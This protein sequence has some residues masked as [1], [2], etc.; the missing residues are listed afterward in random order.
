MALGQLH[1]F[2]QHDAQGNLFDVELVGYLQRL[3]D[4][5]AVLHESHVKGHEFMFEVTFCINL[6]S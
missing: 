1:S 3:S 4:I 2:A 6:C 5:V